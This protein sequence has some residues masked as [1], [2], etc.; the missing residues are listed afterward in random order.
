MGW[1]TDPLL[2]LGAAV[3]G[4][5][6]RDGDGGFGASVWVPWGSLWGC[7]GF[8]VGAGRAARS[9]PASSALSLTPG[10]VSQV[11]YIF[12]PRRNFLLISCP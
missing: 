10:L 6:V 5:G 12:I 4:S 3:G 7:E 11:P 9:L 8:G 1:V 2:R